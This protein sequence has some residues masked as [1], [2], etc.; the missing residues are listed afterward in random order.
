MNNAANRPVFIHGA[1]SIRVGA[2]WM[3]GRVLRDGWTVVAA[4]EQAKKVGLREGPHLT[5]LAKAYIGKYR[6]K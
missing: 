5:E 4:E 1:A 6:K 3:I 2:F